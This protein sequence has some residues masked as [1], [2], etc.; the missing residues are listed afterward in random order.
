FVIS[1]EHGLFSW[2]NYHGVWH[3]FLPHF[4]G[5][6]S[7]WLDT[8]ELIS[9]RR[10]TCLVEDRE[11]NLWIGTEGDGIVRINAHARRFHE[12]EPKANSKD[13]REFTHYGSNDVGCEFMRVNGMS[14]GHEQGVWAALVGRD[15]RR[16]VGRFCDGQW[17]LFELPKLERKTLRDSKVIKTEWWE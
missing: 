1:E 14:A 7:Q 13:G 11:G 12:R 5:A 17:S 4:W 3:H 15:K 2:G 16:W 8:R 6:N 9:H 10:P